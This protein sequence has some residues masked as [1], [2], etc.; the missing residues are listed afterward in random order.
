MLR[1]IREL[2]DCMTNQMNELTERYPA[3]AECEEDIDAAVEA[4]ITAFENGGKLLLCGNGGSAADCEH[5]SGELM[6]GF[7]LSRPFSETEMS[8]IYTRCP[9]ALPVY[10][11]LQRGLPAIPLPSLSSVISASANDISA[12]LAYAQAVAALGCRGDVL[13]AISTS[14]NAENV[15]NAAL[16]AKGADMTVIALTGSS[17][18]R[19]ASAADISIR[20]PE[21]ETYRVQELHLPV[22]HF[23]CASVEKRVFG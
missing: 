21:N 8:E 15:Y 6:K 19:L 22:Y 17:G 18:G 11:K 16:A 12:G 13:L 9:K 2:I 5:I 1:M 14:G 20:V 7:L 4:L 10:G 23:I 3:L